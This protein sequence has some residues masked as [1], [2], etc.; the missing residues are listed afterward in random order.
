[1]SILRSVVRYNSPHCGC[2][3]RRVFAFFVSDNRIAIYRRI[4]GMGR[5]A[6]AMQNEKQHMQTAKTKDAVQ[7]HCCNARLAVNFLNQNQLCKP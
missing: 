3:A 6:D 2:I 5:I 7:L 1:M 4:R